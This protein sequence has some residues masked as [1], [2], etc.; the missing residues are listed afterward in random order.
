[1]KTLLAQIAP[2]RSTQYGALAKD[3][4]RQELLLSP[5]GQGLTNLQYITLAG[6]EYLKFDLA[7]EADSALLYEL[8]LLAMTSAFFIFHAQIGGALGPFLQPLEINFQPALSPDLAATRR[9]RGKTNEL[10]TH[11][12]CNVAR[13]SCTLADN[14]WPNLRVLDPL[15]GG[16]TTLFPA[17]MLGADVA[18]I[19]HNGDDVKAT[20]AF[21]RDYLRGER[22]ACQVKEERFKRLGW[23]WVFTI[24]AGRDKTRPQQCILAS[25]DAV[26]ARALLPGY[27]PQLIVADLP[28]GIQHQGQLNEL[29]TSALPVWTSLLAPQGALTF[30][31]DATRFPRAEMIALVEASAPLLVLD[32]PPYNELA[33][34][35]D[36]VIKVRDVL[37]ARPVLGAS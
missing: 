26:Q 25:G 4:A 13:F 29:L 20:V 33:H 16:G 32:D 30:A 6:H 37:V 27:K 11:F 24:G 5:L 12:L 21:L 34:R 23:R 9:Y 36:R 8:G 22:I 18:G 2:Q 3:L 10:F 31:W 35:V 7:T 28:Y 17:L 15:A 1:M 14:S 19:E